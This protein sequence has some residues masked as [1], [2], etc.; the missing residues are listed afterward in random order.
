MS[1][2]REHNMTKLPSDLSNETWGWGKGIG[3]EAG[4][5][6]QLWKSATLLSPSVL[7]VMKTNN[8]TNAKSWGYLWTAQAILFT[9]TPHPS[10]IPISPFVVLLLFLQAPIKPAASQLQQT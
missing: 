8:V 3:K 5:T 4:Q 1:V 10:H 7:L 2:G 9:H 6:A